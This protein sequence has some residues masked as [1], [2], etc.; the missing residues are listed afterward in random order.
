MD[1]DLTWPS[2]PF[3]HRVAQFLFQMHLTLF[4][5]LVALYRDSHPPPVSQSSNP[6]VSSPMSATLAQ[7]MLQMCAVHYVYMRI[8]CVCQ[9]RVGGRLNAGVSGVNPISGPNV[10]MYRIQIAILP[11]CHVVLLYRI[12]IPDASSI[13]RSL[14]LL[15]RRL[16]TTCIAQGVN[17]WFKR[18]P[19]VLTASLP[20]CF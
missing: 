16:S 4:L 2:R 13:Y 8:C 15:C 6:S 11:C 5:A 12:Q 3:R 7:S 9:R 17:F 10:A 20:Y 1:C 14:P 19:I 18:S